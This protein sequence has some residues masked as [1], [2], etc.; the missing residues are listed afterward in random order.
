MNDRAASRAVSKSATPKNCAVSC[1][2]FIIPRER[3]KKSY[4]L[5]SGKAYT[6]YT[7]KSRLHGILKLYFGVFGSFRCFG[8]PEIEIGLSK[9]KKSISGK[10]SLF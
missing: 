5:R 1:G 2:V 8:V 7:K 9:N 3:D 6:D 10:N 4:L